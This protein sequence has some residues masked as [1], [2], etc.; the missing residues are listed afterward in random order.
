MLI[1]KLKLA[2]AQLRQTGTGKSACFSRDG[3]K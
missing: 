3:G 2:A 1:L